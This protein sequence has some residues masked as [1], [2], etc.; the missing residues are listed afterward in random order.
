MNPGQIYEELALGWGGVDSDNIANLSSA[1]AWIANWNWAWQQ[2]QEQQEE[3]QWKQWQLS[4]LFAPQRGPKFFPERSASGKA[5][6]LV[7]KVVKKKK[8]ENGYLL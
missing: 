2:Q 8:D 6:T 3:S 7:P 5:P 1:E 4:S